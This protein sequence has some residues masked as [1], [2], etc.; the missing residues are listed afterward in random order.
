MRERTGPQPIKQCCT[1][2]LFFVTHNGESCPY[3]G[4]GDWVYG[5]IDA[6]APSIVK[7]VDFGYGKSVAKEAYF[8][9]EC[10]TVVSAEDLFCRNCGVKFVKEEEEEDGREEV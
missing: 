6:P 9:T 4:S 7:G 2:E 3:C 8:C 10:G 5:F 1:C